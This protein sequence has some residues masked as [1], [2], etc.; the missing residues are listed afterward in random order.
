MPEIFFVRHGE[1][2]FNKTH[3]LGHKLN[4]SL[5]EKGK[6]QAHNL[7]MEL[8][9]IKFSHVFSSPF[10]RAKET[11]EIIIKEEN[12]IETID[13]LKEVKYGERDG[14]FR[15]DN[16]DPYIY[17]FE[18]P[19]RETDEAIF[20]RVKKMLEKISKLDGK[21][22]LICHGM[23][24]CAFICYITN[25]KFTL[26]NINKFKLDNAHFNYY[27]MDKKRL[28]LNQNNVGDII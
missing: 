14:A 16:I 22:L 27:D 11:A 1:S 8:Y 2:E 4:T 18:S 12:K 7:A 28:K 20:F 13:D 9:G 6:I 15:P 3:L 21:I 23:I 10:N 19:T 5:T 17:G 24:S 26:E 25:N